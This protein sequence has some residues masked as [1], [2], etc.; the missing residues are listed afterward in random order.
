MSRPS[1]RI[2]FALFTVS[3]FAGLIYQ[4]IWSHYL[5]LFLG[6]AAYAQTLV[7]AIFMGGMAAGSWLA[8][9]WSGRTANLLLG[10]A[11]CELGIGLLA[12]V[13]HPVFLAATAWAFD[14]VL[15][16]LA[17]H[18]TDLFKW[19][20]AS[21]LILPASVLLGATFPLMSGGVIRLHPSL[22][23]RALSMLYFTNSF[24]A[25][26]GVMASGFY[27][28]DR[29]G[30]PGT[31]LT[32]GLMNVALAL[33]VWLVVRTAGAQ[34]SVAPSPETPRLPRD[35]AF[36]RAT[37][38]L[39]FG[40]G[41]AS[42]IYE[43]TWIRMLSSGLGASSH[44]FEVMLAAFILGMSL[45][46]WWLRDRISRIAEATGWLAAILALKAAFAVYA[47]WVYG[48]VLHFMAWTMH[49]VAHTNGGYVLDTAAG[50]AASMLVMFPTAFF[51]GMTLPLATY[52]LTSR[53][54][55]ESAIGKVYAANTAGCIVGAIFATHVGMELLGVKG[56]TGTGAAAD[57]A[58]GVLIY[59][60]GGRS[61]RS[62]RFASGAA[63]AG[64]AAI[65]A[66]YLA[67]LDRLAMSSGVYRYGEFYDPRESAVSF[68]R[69]GKTA[70]ISVVDTGPI[71]TIITNGKPD[72]SIMRDP[73]LHA[74]PDEMTQLLLAALPLAMKP[75][76]QSI[77]NIGFG[78]G[79][80][81]NALLG[82]PRVRR[83]DTIEIERMMVQGARLF[84]PRNRRAFADPRS[85]IH[86]EDAKTYFASEGRR[87]DVITSEPSNPWVSGVSTLFSD[88]FYH[89]VKRYLSH[90]GLF[91]QWIQTYEID[92]DLASTIFNALDR[93]FGDYAVYHAGS[94]LLVV[95][96]PARRLPPLQDEIFSYPGLEA[97]FA[98]L[99]FERLGD[100]RS[101]R[102]GGR[103]A[104]RGLFLSTGYPANSD[105]FPILDQQAPRARFREQGL[106][107]L[108][109]LR[110][111]LAPVLPLLDGDDRVPLG[112]LEHVALNH[113][114]SI[115][116]AD[117][118]GEAIAVALTGQ[119][120][121]A[122]RL[123]P[124][125]RAAATIVHAL[126]GDCRAAPHAWMDAM[127]EVA[128]ATIPFVAK[129]DVEPLLA[130]ARDSSCAHALDE[131]DRHRLAL[132]QAINARDARAIFDEA[133]ALLQHDARASDKDRA[134]YLASALAA[135]IAGGRLA[136]AI[137]LRDAYLLR[138]S[139]AGRRDLA[140]RLALANLA[141]AGTGG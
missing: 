80:T 38:L 123:S 139:A 137:A 60:A 23:G 104:M 128:A 84:D 124:Q 107:D 92:L 49:A 44:A 56:L 62:A 94:D 18:G 71:R 39:A 65:I 16:A 12:M 33:V 17:G 37:L 52:A 96:T 116:L 85:H 119:S 136:D 103:A 130:R 99:G 121:R 76:A 133:G 82:S 43:V 86:I 109:A 111:S 55:G 59:F 46:A 125:A 81:T 51:A 131:M 108:L 69:D 89:Q 73:A 25:A 112:R 24:G 88:E 77:A 14:T 68:Y 1:A 4:S 126:M 22:G 11:L 115:D 21:L 32:A 30:L 36:A 34:A 27:L 10:Y 63:L 93:Q 105:F 91:V 9:R 74:T 31:I 141:L 140:L 101:L 87:Y 20:L 7:L 95:A 47:I 5:K 78:S 138:I 70:T 102:L 35:G 29:F 53:G 6:H 61:I 42:F 117:M 110:G 48:D 135:G 100:L 41:A 114:E 90:D 58:V 98:H 26:I 118:A 127:T 19:T 50:L 120:D 129:D 132:L 66:F 97:D 79:L 15:P 8:A 57:L 75:G 2:F 64:L 72:A 40:T 106:G 28:I 54:F 122:T 13:F 113:P 83:V 3:G 45:G 67:P 134:Y